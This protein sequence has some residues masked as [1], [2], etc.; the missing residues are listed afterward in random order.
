M[1]KKIV[2]ILVLGL[3]IGATVI[4]VAGDIEGKSGIE[5]QI[6]SNSRSIEISSDRA[7]RDWILKAQQTSD[8]NYILFGVTESYGAGSRDAW[9]IKTDSNGN[10]LWNKTW[11]RSACD[12]A[13][14]GQQTSDG[15][16][17]LAGWGR[18]SPSWDTDFWLIKTDADGDEEWYKRYGS[19]GSDDTGYFV[20]KTS[21]NGYIFTGI[22]KSYGAGDWDVWLVKTDGNGD[23]QWN[24]TFGGELTDGGFVVRQ[25]DDGGYIIT[26]WVDSFG[27]GAHDVWLIK[28]DS[29]GDEM[30]NKTFGG[31]DKDSGHDVQQTSDGGYIIIGYTNSYG[32][33]DRDFWLIKTDSSGNEDW[34][35]TFE[36]ADCYSGIEF[37]G[38]SGGMSVRQITDGYIMVGV[39]DASYGNGPLSVLMIETDSNGDELWNK[40]FGGS[41][42]DEGYWINETSDGGYII[43]G[44]TLSYGPPGTNGW[45]IKTDSDGNEDWN[46]TFGGGPPGNR[47]PDAPSKP[48]GPDEG[49]TD[50]EYTFNTSTEDPDGDDVYYLFD[51]GDGNTSSWI[52]PLSSGA[53]ASSSYSWDEAGEYKI[54]VKAK[55]VYDVESGWSSSATIHIIQANRAPNKPTIDGPTEG[56]PDIEYDFI[57]KSVDPDGDN[58]KI[59][60]E[61]GDGY[62]DETE[63]IPSG[64]DVTLSHSWQIKKDYSIQATAIDGDGLESPISIHDITI[65]RTRTLS[66]TFLLQFF[67][68]FPYAFPILRQLIGLI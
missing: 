62:D 33:Y 40:T 15:G 11:G 38:H 8:D 6:K 24:N 7:Y 2:C 9:L 22:T 66:N 25:T 21:D 31:A 1:T 43:S 34:N 12:G 29:N 18:W 23:E 64:T 55:D 51:W 17:I 10:E 45:L 52:G 3:L 4:P 56:K 58:V 42:Y 44:G 16:Y 37:M 5:N 36:G 41:S 46:K 57:F 59:I 26:G 35:K 68:L 32:D 47:P 20:Q 63:Y 60:V 14:S 67:N 27:S 54:K 49:E 53:K 61:W 30:W 48:D 28:T 65:P 50:V 19:V 39:T 13:Q